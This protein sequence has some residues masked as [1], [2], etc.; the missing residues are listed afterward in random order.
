[1]RQGHHRDLRFEG[2]ALSGGCEEGRGWGCGETGLSLSDRALVTTKRY[3]FFTP[4]TSRT[5]RLPPRKP[6]RGPGEGRKGV[7]EPCGHAATLTGSGKGQ[8]TSASDKSDLGPAQR[9]AAGRQVQGPR[10]GPGPAPRLHPERTD[11]RPAPHPASP[12][13]RAR[14]KEEHL[15]AVSTTTG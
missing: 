13:G 10:G 5:S 2:Q 11:R 6:T 1:M 7:S 14:A 4:K 3:F 8:R 15:S 9:P 12:V